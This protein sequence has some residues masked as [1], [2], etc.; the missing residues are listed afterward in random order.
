MTDAF[1][2]LH[3]K[4]NA[5]IQGLTPGLG[6]TSEYLCECGHDTC[7]KTMIALHPAVREPYFPG[8]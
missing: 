3:R 2:V 1:D 5:R 8:V 7:V 4:V 6:G